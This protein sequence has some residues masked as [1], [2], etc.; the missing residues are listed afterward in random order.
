MENY[1]ISA[2]NAINFDKI[3]QQPKTNIFKNLHKTDK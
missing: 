2:E 1:E 3:W